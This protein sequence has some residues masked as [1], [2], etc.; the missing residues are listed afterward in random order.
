MGAEPKK[1]NVL[2]Y[3]AAEGVVPVLGG[4][5]GALAAGPEG[6]VAGVAVGRAVEKAVNL[7]GKG[8]VERWEGWLAARSP[9]EAAAAVSE[10]V[11]L[12]PAEVREEARTILLQ[13][14]PE[15]DQK[16]LDI[17]VEYLS[18]LPRAVDRALVPNPDGAGRTVPP[19]LSLADPRQLLQ[20]LPED[21]PPYPTGADLPGTP[22]RL[23]ELIG[24][25]GFGAVYRAFSPTLQHLPLAIKF[26]LDRGLVPALN[27][28]RSNLE[29]LMRAGGPGSAHV[30]RLYGYDLDHP[31]P[32]L[33]YE[34]VAGGDL[35]AHLAARRAALGRPPGPDEVLGWVIQ[36]A[37]GLAFAHRAGLVHRDLKPAN[38]LVASGQWPVAREDSPAASLSSLATG[39]WPLATLKLADFGLGGVA[40]RRAVLKSRIGASTVDYLSLA[41]QAS[42]FRGAGTPLY[43]SPE[44]RRGADPDPRH[45]LYALGVVWFQSLVG[46]VSRELPHG[47]A[48]EL[49]LRHGVPAAHVELIER[50]VGWYDDRPKDADELLP[51]LREASGG[52]T[53]PE[54]NAAQP[55]TENLGGPAPP[56]RPAETLTNT[57][58][59]TP[60]QPTLSG[61]RRTLLVSLVNRLHA[62]HAEVAERQ[63]GLR[64]W[65]PT[66]V[67]IALAVGVLVGWLVGEWVYANRNDTTTFPQI[68]AGSRF[69]WT[70]NMI[71]VVVG[72]AVWQG[73][74]GLS[75]FGAGVMAEESRKR[76]AA[77][78]EE[79]AAEFPAEVAAWGGLAVL[80]D[81]ATV[82]EVRDA[83]DPP[84]IPLPSATSA[85]GL[86]DLAADSTRRAAVTG[87]LQGLLRQHR[88]TV[89]GDRWSWVLLAGA[90]PVVNVGHAV[91]RNMGSALAVF[92]GVTAGLVAAG[93]VW[94]AAA[95]VRRHLRDKLDRAVGEFAADYPRLVA[96]WG[97]PAVLRDPTAVARVAAELSSPAAPPTPPSPTSTLTPDEIAADPT[98]KAVLIIRL[99]ELDRVRQ[100]TV[101]NADGTWAG[102][103]LLWILA[104]P[105]TAGAVIALL[106]ETSLIREVAVSIGLAVALL[107]GWLSWWGMARI[108]RHLRQKWDEAAGQLVADYPQ[109]VAAWG[110]RGMLQ[111]EETIAA[112]LKTYDPESAAGRPGLVSRLFGG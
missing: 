12:T 56:A 71:G 102:L 108:R 32:F 4:C 3:L 9:A 111:T 63:A 27:Q 22:Y 99:R 61:P 26:C 8:I 86:G 82:R 92:V 41:E 51:L 72:L 11:T 93:A 19:T 70:A 96:E 50:C 44:Q 37:E 34:F 78:A 69:D 13:L 29:R 104:V 25:G 6:G 79:L 2:L 39:H 80:R 28:E 65:S 24:S 88:Q 1:R 10:L 95:R 33:V 35:T 23:V 47:W 67:L 112:L 17:A 45:D 48:K 83:L 89:Q 68:F 31:T 59:V 20:L 7:F 43:M 15:A 55:P 106:F 97:G 91:E 54:G 98:R 60:T 30:V 14:A 107:V 46:D 49:R 74:L 42:L 53:P 103:V 100:N 21:V 110:G 85:V 57:S 77:L 62:A 75:K 18:A 81:P 109:L 38:V 87:R 94:W 58:A 76:A 84:P 40:V 73:V 5:A 52:L 66:F 64:R 36:I 90:L 105:G 101:E 16:D